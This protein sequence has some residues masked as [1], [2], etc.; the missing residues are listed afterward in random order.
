MPYIRQRGSKWYYTIEYTDSDGA[1]HRYERPGGESKTECRKAWRHAMLEIDKKGKHIILPFQKL[2]L[3]NYFT[4]HAEHVIVDILCFQN[5][6]HD[7]SGSFGSQ[8]RAHDNVDAVIPGGFVVHKGIS[9]VQKKH[10]GQKLK[11]TR[12]SAGSARKRPKPFTG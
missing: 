2:T 7:F 12:L 11:M 6:A 9:L 1:H 4:C 5:I 8:G 3:K 10:L